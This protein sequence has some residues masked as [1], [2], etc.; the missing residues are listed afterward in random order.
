MKN[1]NN[2]FQFQQI[3]ITAKYFSRKI[4]IDFGNDLS[5]RQL[6]CNQRNKNQS[7]IFEK[8]RILKEMKN[9]H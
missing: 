6:F 4:L 2:D 9:K 3:F 8:I 1:L 7:D 5:I